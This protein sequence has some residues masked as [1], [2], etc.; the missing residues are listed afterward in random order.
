MKKIRFLTFTLIVLLL[1]AMLAGCGQRKPE[2]KEDKTIKVSKTYLVLSLAALV[3]TFAAIA[4]YMWCL[5]FVSPAADDYTNAVNMRWLINENGG[6]K[7]PT[8][9]KMAGDI[10]A[11]SAPDILLIPETSPSA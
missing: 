8:V 6:A 11:R 9:F 4:L 5:K 7:L 3:L 1:A 2:M 10:T